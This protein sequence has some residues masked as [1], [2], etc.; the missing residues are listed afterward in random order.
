MSS[1]V[2]RLNFYYLLIQNICY[3]LIIPGFGI[4]SHV[5][6][7]FSGKPIF[8]YLGMVYA[9]FSI[10]ILG[11]LVWSHHMFA[12]GLDVDQS[13]F[14]EKILLYAGNFAISSPLVFIA[15]GKIYYPLSLYTVGPGLRSLLS[16]N[17]S[18]FFIF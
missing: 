4:V 9:M 16:T 2:I 6:S 11:F 12:V 15:L 5:V 14:T 13:V 8:G 10:G 7:T 1:W 18:L 3:I 17:P